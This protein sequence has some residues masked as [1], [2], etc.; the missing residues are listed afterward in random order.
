MGDRPPRVGDTVEV[1]I[2]GRRVVA[3]VVD[4]ARHDVRVRT[5]TGGEMWKPLALVWRL[6]DPPEDGGHG[7]GAL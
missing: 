5:E 7:E 2:N 4:V 1:A 3:T 6:P